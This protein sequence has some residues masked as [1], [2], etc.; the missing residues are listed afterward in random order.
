MKRPLL[1]RDPVPASTMPHVVI[2]G[3][4]FAGL[5]AARALAKEPARVTIVDRQNYHLFQPMLYQVAAAALSPGDI[6]Q[7]I[8]AI[9]H[10][11]RNARTLLAEVAAI[12]PT[13]PMRPSRYRDFGTMATI[14]KGA[15][16]AD[17]FGVR[18]GGPLAWLDWLAIRILYLIGF[19]NRLL[20]LTQWAW[21][22]LTDERGARLITAA[23]APAAGAHPHTAAASGD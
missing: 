18:F 7:L 13:E 14:G 22:L 9:L 6:A 16:V 11:Q 15:A 5:Y 17:I 10:H 12:D 20:V 8:R 21:A 4:D 23:P 2:V 1:R 3:G 19:D